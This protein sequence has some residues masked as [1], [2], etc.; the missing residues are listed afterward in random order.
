MRQ[1]L[2]LSNKKERWV[3]QFKPSVKIEGSP[4]NYPITIQKRYSIAINKI[5]NKVIKD[6]EKEVERLIT[7]KTSKEYFAQDASVSSEARMDLNK[8]F[9]DLDRF[10]KKNA[11]N[12]A[13]SMTE[14]VN[15]SSRK[16]VE[17][18]LKKMSGGNPIN[19]PKYGEKIEE[20]LKASIK[21]NV[22]LITN[23]SSDY[24]SKVSDAVNRRILMGGDLSQ[25]RELLQKQKG[26]T[27]RRARNI[28]LDQVRK[29]YTALSVTRMENSGVTKFEWMH[30]AAGK[31]PRK[32]HEQ[33][34]PTGLNGGIFDLND[35]PVIDK[36]TGEKGLPGQAPNC[37]CILIPVIEIE[38]GEIKK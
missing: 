26:M 33:Q 29:A 30:S 4:L 35:P 11:K 2:R 6:T 10:V 12:Y 36:N 15:N 17:S 1:R 18:S 22:D 27:K 21:S 8:I 25:I 24:M 19:L 14:E 23:L 3:N 31:D 20:Q 32:Y 16:N 13:Q 5:I 34:Y 7:S 38:D 9:E 28:A 37:K